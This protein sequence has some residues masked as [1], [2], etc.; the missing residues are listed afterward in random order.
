[1]TLFEGAVRTF[2]VVWSNLFRNKGAVNK[3]LLHIT[4]WLPTLYE[5]AGNFKCFKL[6]SEETLCVCDV[7]KKK[8][9]QLILKHTPIKI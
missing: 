2:G 4:D 8:S 1:M 3:E 6:F 9:F 7:T 5:A